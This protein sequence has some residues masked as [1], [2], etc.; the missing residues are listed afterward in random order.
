MNNPVQAQPIE[1]VDGD[2]VVAHPLDAAT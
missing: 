2:V 1:I